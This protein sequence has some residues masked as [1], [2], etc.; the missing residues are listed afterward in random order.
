VFVSVGSEILPKVDHK[1][2][3]VIELG[4]HQSHSVGE[5]YRNG[6]VLFSEENPHLRPCLLEDGL[7]LARRD[8][9][10]E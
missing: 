4:E 3:L 7:G 10:C 2:P 8:M 1:G 6:L 5:Q 9:G